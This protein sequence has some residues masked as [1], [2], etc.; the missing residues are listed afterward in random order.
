LRYHLRFR[1]N[2]DQQDGET[3]RQKSELPR[4]KVF[5][6]EHNP[7]SSARIL[8]AMGHRATRRRH[9]AWERI[10]VHPRADREKVAV[11]K[12]D[13]VRAFVAG[14]LDRYWKLERE[15]RWVLR[16][17]RQAFPEPC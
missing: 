14:D 17:A 7:G 3:A 15:L 11:V 4:G 8:I 6:C 16:Q 12:H 5:S 10:T 1:R 9:S 13:M 2:D